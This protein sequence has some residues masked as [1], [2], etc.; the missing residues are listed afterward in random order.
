MLLPP[1]LFQLLSSLST[2]V[3]ALPS[4]FNSPHAINQHQDPRKIRS[5]TSPTLGPSSLTVAT[6]LTI[7]DI[8]FPEL[9]ASSNDVPTV[10]CH[11]NP[12]R[13]APPI[14]G[15]VEVVECG[16]L[17]LALL[18]VDPTDLHL[19]RWS[20]DFPIK[21]PYIVGTPSCKMKID[22]IS[23]RSSDVFPRA[24]IAQRAALIVDRC[25]GEQ[26]GVVTLGRREQFQVQIFGLL[27]RATA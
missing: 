16:L 22:A 27:R 7:P 5:L 23:P 6:N 4:D 24:M 19:S 2:S 9:N 1:L 11:V 18:A 21:L 13:P 20:P 8:N 10:F 26:G 25:R 17:V 14:F 15:R 12:Q 3:L